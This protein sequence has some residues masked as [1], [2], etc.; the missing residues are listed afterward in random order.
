MTSPGAFCSCPPSPLLPYPA[1]TSTPTLT[2]SDGA[3]ALSYV[4]LLLF[5]NNRSTTTNK[6]VVDTECYIGQV[7]SSS[8]WLHDGTKGANTRSVPVM[9]LLTGP[10]PEQYDLL[11]KSIAAGT[12]ATLYPDENE[13][14]AA[15]A[16][17]YYQLFVRGIP[18][19]ILILSGLCAAVFLYRHIANLV[20]NSTGKSSVQYVVSRIGLP[21]M[22]LF[23]EMI[24]ATLSGA[25]LAVGGF[26]S[27]PNLPHPVQG[28]FTM[29]MSGW[30]L[31]CSVTSTIPWTRQL[32]EVTGT[33]NLSWF[34]RIMAGERQTVTIFLCLLPVLLDT[35]VASCFSKNYNPPLLED[36]YAIVMTVMELVIGMH[37]VFSTVIR[38]F[39]LASDITKR[40][41]NK[42]PARDVD[43]MASVLARLSRCA[44]G[45]GVSMLLCV[46]G[47]VIIGAAPVYSFTP[48]GFTLTWALFLTGRSLDS[49]FRVSMFKPRWH[50]SAPF[51]TISQP[52]T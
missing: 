30:S 26:G 45:L 10:D 22:T 2:S 43:G 8:I 4:R 49:A 40:A 11:T 1:C 15:Y 17:P 38:Y 48:D 29:S 25:I 32:T 31:M 28:F 9:F 47:M 33:D 34:T 6:S 5:H 16:S 12:N 50:V 42:N 18:S 21:Q 46:V 37:L 3:P 14:S 35:A 7:P 24:T 20:S 52:T 41:N 36:G 19:A 44:L 23:V 39:R 13:W 51:R 27:T